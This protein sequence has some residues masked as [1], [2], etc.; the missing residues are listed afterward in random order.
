MGVAPYALRVQGP[1]SHR[2]HV[3]RETLVLQELEMKR[4][5]GGSFLTS[6]SEL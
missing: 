1:L 3:R 2:Q 4:Q 5:G 6:A